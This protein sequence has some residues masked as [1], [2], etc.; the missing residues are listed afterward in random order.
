TAFAQCKLAIE[1]NPT[2][3]NYYNLGFINVK[4]N[5]KAVA[6]SNFIKSTTLNPKF[7]KS[8]IDLG[9][10]QIDLNKLNK[11]KKLITRLQ[12]TIYQN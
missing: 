1:L 5:N 12:S 6:E 8:F 3:D 2:A 7:I 9:Y 10:V 4:L 11:K